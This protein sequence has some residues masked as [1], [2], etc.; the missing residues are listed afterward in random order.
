MTKTLNELQKEFETLVSNAKNEINTVTEKLELKK[1]ELSSLQAQL[2]KAEQDINIDKFEKV[3]KDLWVAKQTIKMLE[4]K[5][6]NLQTEPLISKEQMNLYE[7]GIKTSTE[8]QRERA[9][10]VFNTV[11]EEIKKAILLD[12]EARVKGQQLLDDLVS[13]IVRNNKQYF[14]TENGNSRGMNLSLNNRETTLS[15]EVQKF[16]QDVLDK[17]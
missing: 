9:R 5:L 12:L 7:D 13:K 4:T 1:K 11:K 2:K 16:I 17:K 10:E 15:Y 8:E 14:V 6:N 3:N